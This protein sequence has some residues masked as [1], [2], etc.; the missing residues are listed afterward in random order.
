M[1]AIQKQREDLVKLIIEHEGNLDV[2]DVV[3]FNLFT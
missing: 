1:F 2:K 3:S